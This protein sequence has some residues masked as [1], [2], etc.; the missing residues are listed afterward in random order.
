MNDNI[1]VE[2]GITSIQYL[3]INTVSNFYFK[4][5]KNK[6]ANKVN[7]VTNFFSLNCLLE[8]K[9]VVGQSKIEID[10]NEY[11]YQDVITPNSKGYDSILYIYEIYAKKVESLAPKDDDN[12]IFYASGLEMDSYLDKK[13]FADKEIVIP[14]NVQMNHV[15]NENVQSIKFLF[16]HVSKKGDVILDLNLEDEAPLEIRISFENSQVM[17]KQLLGRSRSVIIKE[18]MFRLNETQD[19]VIPCPDDKEVCNIIIEVFARANKY[20][21]EGISFELSVKTNDTIPVYVRKNLLREDLV[22]G[23]QVQYYF[24][25]I[26]KDE[27]GEIIV[28]FNRGSGKMFAKL[29][30]KDQASSSDPYAWMGKY[31]LP[32][33]NENDLLVFNE[34]T[35]TAYYTKEDTKNC[36]NGCYLVIGVK[37][38]LRELFVSDINFFIYDLTV[39]IREIAGNNQIYVNIPADQYIVGN[40][41]SSNRNALR[42]FNFYVPAYS[43]K[44][45]IEFQSEVCDLY[46]TTDDEEP[47]T[48]KYKK[49]FSSN[50]QPQVF[51]ITSKDIEFKDSLKNKKFNFAIGAQ[52]FDSIEFAMFTMKLRTPKMN[53][54]EYIQVNSDQYTLCESES[55][56]NNTCYFLIDVRNEVS[57]QNIYMHAWTNLSSEITHITAKVVDGNEFDLWDEKKLEEF[58]PKPGEKNGKNVYNSDDY[59]PDHLLIPILNYK[60][61]DYIVIAV[62]SK[63]P[64]TI[65]YL[66]SFYTYVKSIVPN[67]NTYT[68]FHIYSNERAN[69][70]INFTFPN[71]N[72]YLIHFVSVDNNGVIAIKNNN[73][74]ENTYFNLRGNHDQMA[75]AMKSKENLEV[76]VTTPNKKGLGFYVYYEIRPEDNF[77]VVQFGKSTQYYYDFYSTV[78]FPIMYYA[79]IPD[80][81]DGDIDLIINFKNLSYTQEK[82]DYLDSDDFTIKGVITDQETIYKKKR[83]RRINP[84]EKN[85]IF[86]KFDAGVRVGKIHYTKDDLEKI[87][88]EKIRFVYVII[89]KPWTNLNKYTSAQ[90]EITVVASNS[91]NSPIQTNQYIVGNLNKGFKGFV[92][93]YFKKD[94]FEDKF[95]FV[96]FATNGEI[97]WAINEKSDSVNFFNNG[98]NFIENKYEGGRSIVKINCEENSEFYLS[99]FYNNKNHEVKNEKLANFIFKYFS[100]SSYE[101]QNYSPKSNEI[102]FEYNENILKL[103][104]D[105]INK[106][107]NFVPATYFVKVMNYDKKDE[108]KE[109][110]ETIS[111]TESEPYTITRDIINNKNQLNK[112]GKVEIS[113]KNIKTDEPYDFVVFAMTNENNREYFSYK[114]LVNPLNVKYSNKSSNRGI[115]L[116]ILL[117]I[118]IFGLI[119]FLVYIYF[120]MKNQNDELKKKVESISFVGNNTEDLLLSNENKDEG[121]N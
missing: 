31:T 13:D 94:E 96:E 88:K 10:G 97:N 43:D 21:K 41:Q 17:H 45:L 12:C 101:K 108:I 73:G 102:D 56:N 14:E 23:G 6:D 50:G 9:R 107:N 111:F 116:I 70:Y 51:K 60:I 32:I 19:G 95:I 16:P 71:D 69:N 5:T 114:T 37:S 30:N 115:G 25:D 59:E 49:K 121:I 74:G 48:T 64:T 26:R 120:R 3:K 36:K 105:P 113:F 118:V 92:K 76:N 66:S 81:I 1:Y 2:S 11:Y 87:D 33:G 34:Y 103:K 28:N 79:Q 83:N 85:A 99:V 42:L 77:D 55:K 7:F 75:I 117:I 93:Y 110:L 39:Y 80:N 61:G 44:L 82:T 27:S 8:I 53:F 90:T 98:T 54:K 67:S 62:Q 22:T 63:N 72:N 68:L 84:S 104:F 119:A 4:N 35:K 15:L 91:E 46:L 89:E 29:F 57:V 18:N 38:N 100:T 86:G 52:S 47:S 109:N 24:T 40:I 106:D 112:N 20:L 58:T 65:F 78:N